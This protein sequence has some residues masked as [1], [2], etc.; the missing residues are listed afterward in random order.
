MPGTAPTLV[1]TPTYSPDSTG[2]SHTFTYPT[3]ILAGDVLLLQL[4]AFSAAAS[5]PVPLP[6]G[7]TLVDSWQNKRNASSGD[8][9]YFNTYW[10]RAGSALSGTFAVP[11]GSAAL[12]DGMVSA[13]R[14]CLASGS[15]VDAHVVSEGTN[16]TSLQSG[17]LTTTG[18][19]RLVV[20]MTGNDQGQTFTA[21]AGYTVASN[22]PEQGVFYKA[23]AVQDSASAS[24]TLANPADYVLEL[25]ALAPASRTTATGGVA[26]TDAVLAGTRVVAPTVTGSM[27]ETDAVLPGTRAVTPG[28]TPAGAVAE[29]GLVFGATV[30]HEAGMTPTGAVHETDFV[31]GARALHGTLGASAVVEATYPVPTMP[32]YNLNDVGKWGHRNGWTFT[33]PTD[34]VVYGF[35]FPWVYRGSDIWPVAGDTHAGGN[36]GTHR[37]RILPYDEVNRRPDVNTVL[38]EEVPAL[39]TG[40]GP[41]QGGN[42]R[43]IFERMKAG[44]GWSS[45]VAGNSGGD[46]PLQANMLIPGGLLLKAG[47]LYCFSDEHLNTDTSVNYSGPDWP[48]TKAAITLPNGTSYVPP[49]H[50]NDPPV[51]KDFVA[52]VSLYG[53][54]AREKVYSMPGPDDAGAPAVGWGAQT[55][56]Y[57]G[58]GG[59]DGPRIPVGW[60]WYSQGPAVTNLIVG[61][62]N[63]AG[64]GSD[65]P[66]RAK[67]SSAIN[68]DRLTTDHSETVLALEAEIAVDEANGIT[69]HMTINASAGTS[70]ATFG[71]HCQ[72]LFQ[73]Y[74]P[75]GARVAQIGGQPIVSWTIVNEPQWN[76]FS[77][78]QYA[79]LLSAAADARDALGAGQAGHGVRIFGTIA[80]GAVGG[81]DA[82][83]QAVVA[84][85]PAIWSRY[86]GFD[87]HWYG[88]PSN[89]AGFVST[90]DAKVGAAKTWAWAQ[91]G[92]NG[93][94]FVITEWNLTADGTVEL[95]SAMLQ[96]QLPKAVAKMAAQA[97]I[98]AQYIFEWHATG[99]WKWLSL[100]GSPTAPDPATDD[101]I[102]PWVAPF[103]TAVVAALSQ[104]TGGNPYAAGSFHTKSPWLSYGEVS[105]SSGQVRRR[106]ASR[107]VPLTHV[108]FYAAGG[109]S[110]SGQVRILD[111]TGAQVDVASWQKTVSAPGL[112]IVSLSKLVTP[113]VG[114]DYIETWTGGALREGTNHATL[115]PITRPDLNTS[116]L[117]F[118]AAGVSHT[119]N[120]PGVGAFG[121]AGSPDSY[122]TQ[123]STL[124]PPPEPA[125]PVDLAAVLEGGG[126]LENAVEAF[127]TRVDLSADF[128]G[129]GELIVSPTLVS[130]VNRDLAVSL[131]A[132]GGLVVFVDAVTPAQVR[133]AF[134]GSGWPAGMQMLILPRYFDEPPELRY[135]LD[136]DTGVKTPVL[137]DRVPVATVTADVEGDWRVELPL[138]LYWVVGQVLGQWRYISFS[139]TSAS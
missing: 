51:A 139:V 131:E 103:K 55:G 120:M 26:E 25:V 67:S 105:S 41:G 81:G 65:D 123:G 21:P 77:G 82:F 102:N 16:T 52:T 74:G 31:R 43:T 2:T 112:C 30:V 75:G 88:A 39:W 35:E 104:N 99:T 48:T 10:L 27:A 53:G 135:D 17:T 4:T 42:A 3:G 69:P 8:W 118:T 85:I 20:G 33:V 58:G 116:D 132:G 80:E 87:F 44:Y 72:T 100:I 108:A 45:T 122:T 54:T 119:F 50:D 11:M 134:D 40:S 22:Q 94:P 129:G 9:F 83:N 117:R 29:T 95:S 106:Q 109:G 37:F 73:N 66:P 90:F 86:D 127:T 101:T 98:E 6:A 56:Y 23:L 47:V 89:P 38:A 57:S 107:A 96:D 68:G 111:V 76:G 49:Q 7:W 15:P 12:H 70:P 60:G 46:Q 130:S 5:N 61:A 136:R 64:W 110:Y 32:G 138:G 79:S 28:N 1:G 84:A 128:E 97:W 14:G 137:L 36:G 113:I 18:P 78:A 124:P 91:S 62:V 19:N 126:T 125:Q 71:A 24:G 133:V 59:E 63:V 114:A 121:P 34:R 92:G 115:Y 93:K 13:F